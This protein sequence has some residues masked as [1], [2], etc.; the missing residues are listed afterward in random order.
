MILNAYAVLDAF[1]SLL[2]LL[3][4]MVVL[5]LGVTAWRRSSRT[6]VPNA[7]TTS[8]AHY[9]L[10]FLL[11]LL[12]MGL[13]VV[14]WPLLYLLL[15]S[16]VPEW[17]E[18]M[19]IFGVTQ[20][21]L[22][23]MGPARFLPHLIST[24][25]VTKPA[26]VFLS[27]AWL[28]LHLCNRTIGSS[29]LKRCTY[30][31]L[32]GQSLFAGIDAAAESAY[33]GIPK[34]ASLPS[35]GC[36][37]VAPPHSLSLSPT[38]ESEWFGIPSTPVLWSGYYLLNAGLIATLFLAT[39]GHSPKLPAVS[40]KILLV[41]AGAIGVVSWLFLAEIAAPVMLHLPQHHCIYDLISKVP[42]MNLGIG[43]HVFG[44]FSIGWANL[45]AW[46]GDSSDVKPVAQHWTQSLVRLAIHGYGGSIVMISSGLLMA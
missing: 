28:V 18:T 39:I 45:V 12:L 36:C 8:E 26:V 10:M 5:T 25:Q 22:N 34:K 35:V 37:T 20:V 17:S 21:G 6:D 13:N 1:V 42:E 41:A 3:V 14:S 31:V 38:L 33:L 2:R 19:C 9:Y 32:I 30:I 16:Y 29:S 4:A 43:L 15:Q 40:L 24:L 46:C 11:A 44:I 23:S 7:S 27:G